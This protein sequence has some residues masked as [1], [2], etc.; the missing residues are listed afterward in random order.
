MCRWAAYLGPETFLEAVVSAPR[1]SLIAQSQHALRGKAETNGD[2]FGIAWYGYHPEP[3]L[4]RDILPAWSDPNLRNLARHVRSNLFLAHVRRST[5]TASNRSNCHPFVVGRWSF[6]HNGEIGGYENVRQRLD[7]LLPEELYHY[8][9]GTTDSEVMFLLALSYGLES[10][11]QGAIA[12]MAGT[13]ETVAKRGGKT[14]YLRLTAAFSEGERLYAVRYSS[15][16]LAPS[17]C[18]RKAHTHGSRTVASEPLDAEQDDWQDVPPGSF[19]VF[20]AQEVSIQP[21]API[22]DPALLEVA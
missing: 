12:R 16:E 15:D 4:Y 18:Y 8:R 10:D 9:V 3:G 11:P 13:V 21:F 22:V 17:L 2:G 5:G 7:R 19:A 14:P 6:M 20:T 1:Q